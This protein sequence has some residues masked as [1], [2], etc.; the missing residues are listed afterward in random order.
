LVRF[1]WVSQVSPT[2]P[3]CCPSTRK[4]VSGDD[5]KNRLHILGV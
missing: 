2:L 1:T 4:G 3:A 5:C